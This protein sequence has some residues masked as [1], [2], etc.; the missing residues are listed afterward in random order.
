M[1]RCYQNDEPGLERPD[2]MLRILEAT[3]GIEPV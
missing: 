1:R 2:F 3:T